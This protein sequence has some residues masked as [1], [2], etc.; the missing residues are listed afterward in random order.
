M[1]FR[2]MPLLEQPTYSS[3]RHSA[4]SR[5]SGYDRMTPSNRSQKGTAQMK[6]EPTLASEA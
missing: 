5:R 3:P 4:A 6:F 2:L 1:D